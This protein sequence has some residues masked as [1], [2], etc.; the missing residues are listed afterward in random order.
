MSNTIRNTFRATGPEAFDIDYQLAPQNR[1]CTTNEDCWAAF[2]W[3]QKVEKVKIDPDRMAVGGVS[4]GGYLSAVF[5]HLCRD[6]NIPLRL[7]IF[8]VPAYDSNN[9]F[10]PEGAFNRVKWPHESY[11]EMKFI[12]ALPTARMTYLHTSWKCL[13]QQGQTR[14]DWRINSMLASSLGLA[15]ALAFT[16]EMDRLRDE[17]EA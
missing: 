11:R 5:V 15:L 1:H 12:P 9:A 2:N 13:D 6:V 10:T 14:C 3:F 16:A 7:Q 4:V 8:N 17:G